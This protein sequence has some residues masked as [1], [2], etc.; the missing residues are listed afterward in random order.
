MSRD[1]IVEQLQKLEAEK[2]DHNG[3]YFFLLVEYTRESTRIDTEIAILHK[4]ARVW[5]YDLEQ[6]PPPPPEQ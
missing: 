3:R 5:G 2:L 1:E 4:W 6:T